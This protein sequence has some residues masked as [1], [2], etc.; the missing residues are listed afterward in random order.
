GARSAPTLPLQ[1]KVEESSPPDPTLPTVE[2]TYGILISGIGGTGVVTVGAILAMAAHLDGKA[3]GVIDMAGL[4]QKGGSVHSHVRIAARP[5]DIHAIRLAAQGADLVLGG[6][7]V[8][9]AGRAVL[10]TVKPGATRVVVNTAEVMPGPFTR[11]PDLR[12]PAER[13][14]RAI[15]DAA[16]GSDGDPGPVRFLDA[17]AVATALFGHS[18]AANVVLLGCAFQLGAV[19][20]SAAAIERAIALNGEAVETTLAAFRVGRRIAL[21]PAAAQALTAPAVADP[22]SPRHLS[23]SL[24]ETIARRVAVLTAYQDAAYT[25]R[26]RARVEAVRAIEAERAPGRTALTEAVAKS[27]FR[28]MAVKDEYEVARLWT[29]G[30]FL[31]QLGESFAGTPR[32][33]LHL[34]PPLLARKDRHGVARKITVGP[35]IFPVLRGLAACKRLRRTRLDPFGWTAERR[36]EWAL[37]GDY[38]AVL[39]EVVGG[40]DLDNHALAV[41]LAAVP[42]HIRGFGHVK[43]RSIALAKAEEAMLLA[44]FRSPSLRLEAAE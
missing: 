12:L 24:E 11:H 8:V 40:L 19:P 21:D 25:A 30:S 22:A 29:D 38:E 23:G 3:A 16:R 15:V 31:R 35:W 42:E 14:R 5:E 18:I 43:M 32:L 26:Y 28:L 27:L 10:A 17:G 34:A 2:K 4:A 33:R 41:A 39:D 20:L 44:E 1:G 36:A 13:L 6:D 7:L 37:V 9:A